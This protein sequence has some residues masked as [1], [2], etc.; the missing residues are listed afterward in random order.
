MLGLFDSTCA[1]PNLLIVV[2]SV[3]DRRNR[4]CAV[5][6]S[7]KPCHIMWNLGNFKFGFGT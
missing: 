2:L 7:S 6:M 1:M 4:L 5:S 3:G